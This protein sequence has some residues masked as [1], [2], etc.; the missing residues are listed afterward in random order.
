[1]NVAIPSIRKNTAL[2]AIVVIDLM[3]LVWSCE[4]ESGKLA[5]QLNSQK[6]KEVV[7]ALVNK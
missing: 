1:M 3:L 4:N 7:V 6:E 5:K 2:V